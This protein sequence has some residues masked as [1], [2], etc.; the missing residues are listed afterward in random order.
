MKS[1]KVLAFVL[2]WLLI[3]C[4]E[5]YTRNVSA[6][7]QV[8]YAGWQIHYAE[9]QVYTD[10]LQTQMKNRKTVFHG[11]PPVRRGIIT[12]DFGKPVEFATVVLSYGGNSTENGK[13]G[14]NTISVAVTD[15]LG[16]YN[17][18]LAAG[19][20]V[21]EVRHIAYKPYKSEIVAN[22]GKSDF[23]TV[24]LQAQ[25][26]GL[27][28]ITLTAQT[29][30]H[31]S[32][33]FLMQ[34][35][36]TPRMMNKDAA[37]VLRLAPGVW[38]NDK[39]VSINGTGGTK[40]FINNREI[41]LSGSDLTDYL[42]N[43]RSSDIECVEIVPLAGARYSA[44]SRGGVVKIILRR[45]LKNGMG[46]NLKFDRIEGQYAKGYVPSGS[47][48]ARVG[49]WTL[50][51]FASGNIMQKGKEEITAVRNYYGTP[52]DNY[53][54]FAVSDRKPHTGLGRLGAFY[55]INA[56]NGIGIETEL[57]S[58]NI[59]SP[60]SAKTDMFVK[61][62]SIGSKS[63]YMQKEKDRDFSATL[64]YIHKFDSCGTDLK[65]IADYTN[66]K[67]TGDNSYHSVFE[68]PGIVCDSLFRN[69][70]SSHYKIYTVDIAYEHQTRRG[71]KYSAGAKFTRNDMTDTVRYESVKA[72]DWHPMPGYCYS[73][74]Y[75]EN[76]GAAYGTFS[77]N[78]GRAEFVAGLRGEYTHTTGRRSN[79]A[80]KSYFDLFPSLSITYSFD[81]RHKF[82]L[83][84]QYSRSIERPNF[85]YLNPNRIQY[86]DYS[87]QIGNPGLRPTYINRANVTAIYKYRYVISAG[88]NFHHN[89]IREVCKTDPGDS[90]V[91]YIIPENH[92]TENH[93]YVSFSAPFNIAEWWNW[94]V[95]LIGVRQVIK[96]KETDGRLSHYLYFVNLTTG[97]NLSS[98]IY[99]EL[100]YN[101]T[102]RLYSAN[103]GVQPRDL[104]NV[105]LKKKFLKRRFT[106][107]LEMNNV[108]D[109][110]PAYFSNMNSFKMRTRSLE[111]ESSRFIKIGLQYNFRCG[112]SFKNRKV[113]SSSD[114]GKKRL[115][116]PGTE[117]K[118]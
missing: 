14:N 108:F 41:K 46:G 29:L 27:K 63:D 62:I 99:L 93:Y 32:D 68:F 80:H 90:N 65:V 57:S 82:M 55:E 13:S 60:Y 45:Q 39:G 100:A 95:N 75:S 73:L 16:R 9:Q 91:T 54:S 26:T 4:S 83:T 71:L 84:G 107:S 15:S 110:R 92:R 118:L 98:G 81:A 64:N 43:F 51:G 34:V 102:S 42:R 112:I 24:K 115:E 10:S 5:G 72:G 87:Y 113:E 33:R 69:N 101:G 109:S 19:K 35:N 59:R 61:G 1:F 48:N 79:D 105:A 49:K 22:G 25:E 18:S 8:Y 78:L 40:V 47:I 20:Y 94:N 17:F 44:D 106:A 66:K 7:K 53:N 86:S 96:S 76:I 23:K 85:W 104:F 37:E 77:A 56:K 88:A 30:T 38:V 2:V 3:F 21:M 12:D 67:V 28:G 97:F 117:N 74:D 103:S 6:G 50:N 111:S 36:N 70:S 52:T 116:R 58:R 114:I 11:Q 31:K 89:L